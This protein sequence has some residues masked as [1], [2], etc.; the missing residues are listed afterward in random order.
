MRDALA[1][2]VVV[3]MFAACPPSSLAGP[4]AGPSEECLVT[5]PT[6][7]TQTQLRWADIEPVIVSRCQPCHDG[8]QPQ[9]PLR[10]YSDVADWA[11]IVRQ[12]VVDCTMPPLDGGLQVGM[13]NVERRLILDWIKC[14]Y[15]R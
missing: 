4:D 12:H 9:W 13:T 5:A 6:T 2:G 15:P 1:A 3:V 7:C 14:S 11:D 8:S 10:T